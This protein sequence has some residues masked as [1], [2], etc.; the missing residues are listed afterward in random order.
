MSLVMDLFGSPPLTPHGFCL[1]WNPNLMLLHVISDSL[2]GI[3]YFSIPLTLATFLVQRQDMAFRG[4]FW[5]F[6]IFILACG[7]THFMS[8]WTLWYPDYGLEG[9][10]KGVTAITSV[11]TAVLIWLLVPQALALPSPAMLRQTNLDLHEQINLRDTAVLALRSETV[12]RQRAEAMLSQS[13]KMEAVG[14]LTGGIAHDFNNI[15]MV[16]VA[17]LEMLASR[18]DLELSARRYVERAMGSANRGAALIQQLLAF[19]RRQPL[20]PVS[21]DVNQC[22]RDM[23][24]LLG[25][26]LGQHVLLGIE[27]DAALWPAEADP[28]QLGSALLNLALNARD[29]MP[30]GGTVTVR[31][32]NTILDAADAASADAT[33]G[34]YI[35]VSVTDSGTGMSPDIRSKAFEP[36]VTTKPAGK[37]SGLGLSQVYGFVK[38]SHGHV[39]LHSAPGRGTTVVLYLRRA[40]DAHREQQSAA[41]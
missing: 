34:P 2:T 39:E 26:T 7:S 18:A 8:I 37:G 22:V 13:Q 33:P 28:S 25:S 12:E 21:F 17:N 3:A 36:F 40:S 20:K 15:L 38:Q 31:T 23:T 9:M 32:A 14:L 29:A 30:T 1:S 10:V 41:D 4:V 11:L 24:Q 35:T 19:A 27:T 16:V 5:L 6:A